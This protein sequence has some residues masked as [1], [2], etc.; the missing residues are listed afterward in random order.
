MTKAASA[1]FFYMGGCSCF[2]SSVPER[3]RPVAVWLGA[4]VHPPAGAIMAGGLRRPRYPI[5]GTGVPG[6]LV[7]DGPQPV[8]GVGGAPELARQPG[9][10]WLDACGS[11]GVRAAAAGTGAAAAG[12]RCQQFG[13]KS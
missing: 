8:A 10:S 9:G 11:P 3:W 6:S 4:G 2:K 13:P 7:L 1:A 12:A 5:G